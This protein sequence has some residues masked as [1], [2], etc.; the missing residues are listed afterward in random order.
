MPHT[1]TPTSAISTAG[2]VGSDYDYFSSNISLDNNTETA[3]QPF[4]DHELWEA[5]IIIITSATIAIFTVS[6]NVMVWLSFYMD[7]QLQVVNNYFILSLAT[8]DI[9]IGAL[10]IPIYTLYLL[11]DGWRLG[12]IFCDIWLSIDYVASNASVM[13]LCIICFDRFLSVT[14]PLTYRA[15]RTPRKAKIMIALAWIVSVVVWIPLIIGWQ[16]FFSEGRNVPDDDC[17]IQFINDEVALNVLTILIAFYLPVALMGTLYYKIWRE[18]EKRSLELERL[19]EGGHTSPPARRLLSSEDTDDEVGV[20]VRSQSKCLRCPCCLIADL[21]DEDDDSS[22][23]TIHHNS[24][25]TMSYSASLKSRRGSRA[26]P[27][28]PPDSPR[29]HTIRES[30]RSATQMNG[31]LASAENNS[32]DNNKSFAASLYT[33]LIK[34]PDES[35]NASEED[36]LPKITMVE[37]SPQREQS[38]IQDQEGTR[39]MPPET[40]GTEKSRSNSVASNNKAPANSQ[41]NLSISTISMV[42][43]MASRAKTNVNRKRKSQL[44]RE[45]K[46]ARTLCAILLAFI[47][48][49]T[50]YSILV[51]ISF[52]GFSNAAVSKSFE[53]AYWLCYLNSTLNPICYALCNATFRRAFKRILTCQ[54]TPR[55]RRQHKQ[56]QHARRRER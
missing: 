33:I 11:Q 19:Q 47:I 4:G 39:L 56:R 54:W 55:H 40:N 6:A 37:E 31:N 22:D 28:L 44:I 2:V 53:V 21:G 9:I 5:I 35:P 13:N 3:L 26:Q 25:S 48:T 17:Y 16:F 52:S 18:T 36:K 14:R 24:P 46:A 27:I 45:K 34:L 1:L 15:N 42:N 38:L 12:N 23:L 30:P 10:S 41:S 50:P 20:R 51:L 7:K 29:H 8:A 32:N 43:K 49:W